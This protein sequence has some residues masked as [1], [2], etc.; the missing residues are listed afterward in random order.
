MIDSATEAFRPVKEALRSLV[1][2]LIGSTPFS[3]SEYSGELD[4]AGSEVIVIQQQL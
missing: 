1:R 4:M 3:G 2:D